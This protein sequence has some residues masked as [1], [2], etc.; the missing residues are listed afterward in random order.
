MVQEQVFAKIADGNKI[1]VDQVAA[2]IATTAGPSGVTDWRGHFVLPQT[3]G[4]PAGGPYQF[5]ATDGRSGQ[6]NILSVT[7]GSR[8]ELQVDF[9]GSGPFE[10]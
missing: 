7:A 9:M 4:I 1:V 5:K 10:V 8:R 2:W 6:I 3:K